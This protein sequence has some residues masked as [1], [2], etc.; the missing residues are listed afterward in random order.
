[1]ERGQTPIALSQNA[2]LRYAILFA[3]SFAQGFPIGLFFYAIPIWLASNQVSA[4]SI[5]LFVSAATLPWTFKFFSGFLMDRFTFLPMGR[6]RIWLIGSQMSI[7]VAL[8][9]AALLSPTTGQV[10]SLAAIA[11]SVNTLCS[12]QDTA[13]NGLAV[14]IVP[15]EERA[16]ANGF[17]LAGEAVGTAV[18]T[19]L[20]GLLIA[21]FGIASAFIGMAIF[22]AIV[23]SFIV[24]VRERPGERLLPWSEGDTWDQNASQQAERWTHLLARVW[25]VMS[26]RNSVLLALALGL[27]GV[28]VGLYMVIAPIIA[29]NFAGWTDE[30]FAT[31]NGVAGLSAG[32]AGM[33][34]FGAIVQR[35]GAR[36]GRTL[37]MAFFTMAGL[38]LLATSSIWK[39][40][41]VFI[42]VIF[43][44]FLS[45]AL[46]RVGAYVT[47]MRLCDSTGAATQFALFLACANSGVI[48]S[49]IAVGVL[50]SL[51]GQTLVLASASAA[52]AIATVIFW[53]IKLSPARTH[54]EIA[55]LD[56]RISE[57]A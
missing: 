34:I 51:G 56:E 35:I 33:L 41:Y 45:D 26:E 11:F 22:V 18:G 13:I 6:R 7:V 4:T 53:V 28:T 21:S 29:T 50:D 48:L 3:G 31:L 5:G 37:G 30:G 38:V 49:G 2:R 32:L 15:D 23:L 42:G 43:L 54:D 10:V 46:M 25:R 19:I 24:A 9:A 52:G 8:I 44:V 20:S 16:Q 14:D 40:E 39:A 47:A 27:Y 12:F 57:S 36:L 55:L 1:M 17:L